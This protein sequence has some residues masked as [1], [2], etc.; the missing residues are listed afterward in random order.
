MDFDLVRTLLIILS[1]LFTVIAFI[2][3]LVGVVKGK[4]KPRV[5]SWFIWSLL[6]GIGLVAALVEGQYA[7][8]LLLSLATLGTLS[9]VIL[10][11]KFG[12]RKIENLDIVCLAGAAVGIIMWQVSGVPAVGVIA[13][14]GVDFIGG[15]PTLIHAWKKPSEE[16]WITFLM[17]SIGSAFTLMALTDWRVTAFAFPLYLVLINLATAVIILLMRRISVDKIQLKSKSR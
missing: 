13:A 10:G 14:I 16:A 2:P 6:T 5:V 9:I 17:S 4:T 11:I 12:D 15:V 1:G 3:Y 8:A 7:T